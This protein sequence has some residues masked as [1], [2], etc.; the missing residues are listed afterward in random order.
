[1]TSPDS[2]FRDFAVHEM[3]FSHPGN[4][5]MLR[6]VPIEAPVAIEVCGIGYAV[7][8][9]TP[10]HLDDYAVGFS[11]SEGLVTRADQ[12]E[13]VEVHAMT[14]DE[15]VR[16]GWIVRISLQPEQADRV[17]ARIR[18]RVSESSC[19]LCGVENV[20]Q[21][22]RPL[23]PVTT[24]IASSRAAI[25][26]A[27]STLKEHQPLGEATGAVHAAAFCTPRGDIV[28]VREDV[29]RHNALDKLIGA[30]AASGIAPA[31]GF[32]LLSAR[33]SYELVEKTVRAGCPMLV[34]ISAPTSLAVERA[35]S[36]R[37]TLVS[38]ARAD[39][40]LLITDSMGNI[41]SP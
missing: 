25:V 21:V 13:S 14:G 1:M 30:L 3:G 37:L 27:L 24:R 41:A 31:S 15:R 6:H 36:A 4:C 34:T 10:S 20:E 12:I 11:L 8:M 16:G 39:S 38:L 17:F 35:V 18:K 5:E 22:L 9:A 2:Q 26:K 33:C 29:G 40:A 28:C 23:P 7:M 19:G 32:I